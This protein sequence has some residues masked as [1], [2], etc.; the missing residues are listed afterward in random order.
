MALVVIAE[1]LAVWG[2]ILYY[3]AKVSHA[4]GISRWY[5]LTTPLGAG[6]F[7][8]MMLTSAWKVLSGQGV[9]WKGR[10]YD[11]KDVQVRR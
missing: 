5:A 7:A 3:R 11:P 6:V 2:S 9:T 8:A 1:A 4:M 10:K